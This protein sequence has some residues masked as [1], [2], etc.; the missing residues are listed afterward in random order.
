MRSLSFLLIAGLLGSAA[1]AQ[2]PQ[3]EFDVATGRFIGCLMATVRMG[4]TTRMDPDTFQAGLDKSC[5]AE[6]T[7]FRA[8]AIKQAI[9]LGRTEAEAA[10]EVE[11]NIARGRAAFAADQASYMRT[12]KVPK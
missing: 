11:G 10:A 7:G 6:E 5:K 9:A 8:A 12:G 1:S 2:P 3:G 4:M